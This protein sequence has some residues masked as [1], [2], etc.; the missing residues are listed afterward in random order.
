M[1]Y[2]DF[3]ILF[4]LILSSF[5]GF[6]RGFIKEFLSLFAYIISFLITD[7]IGT[8]LSPFFDCYIDSIL[9]KDCLSCLI[10]LFLSLLFCSLIANMISFFI[11][12]TGISNINRIFGALFGFFRGLFLVVLIVVFC[13]FTNLSQ[14][15]YWVDSIFIDPIMI[16]IE[17]IKLY[18]PYS[19][20]L[21]EL[22]P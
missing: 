2:F 12:K 8:I 17:N 15:L 18:L 6:Y 9:F 22:L 19:S 11:N 20:R 16:L 4:I 13:C 14:E 7:L 5:V 3:F 1:N 10:V 21:K